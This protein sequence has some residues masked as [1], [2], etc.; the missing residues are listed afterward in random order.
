[1][2]KEELPWPG[3]KEG[4]GKAGEELMAEALQEREEGG[5]GVGALCTPHK[6]AAKVQGCCRVG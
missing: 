6:G 3:V 2:E 5:G 1:M 4:G